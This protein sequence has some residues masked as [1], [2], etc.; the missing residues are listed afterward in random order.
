[1]TETHICP[2]C[3]APG[4]RVFFRSEDV[5][6]AD[7]VFWRTREAAIRCAK[8]DV[9]LAF[10]RRCECI[11]NL[12]LGSGSVAY[13]LDYENSLHFS[14]AFQE[15]AKA[16]AAELV[17]RHGLHNKTIVEI[18]CGKG[19]FLAMLCELGHNRGIG[20]DPS[21]ANGRG[22]AAAGAGIS[23]IREFYSASSAIPGCDFICCRH[24]LEHIPTPTQFLSDVRR[25][26]EKSGASVFFEVPNGRYTLQQNGIWDIIYPHATYFVSGSLR[27][28]FA[29]C[30]F[31]VESLRESFNG[32]YLSLEASTSGAAAQERVAPAF[33]NES[34]A[35][36]I[37]KFQQSYQKRVEDLTK[38]LD[39]LRKS[40]K[41]A[42][43]WGGGSKGVAFL[44]RF[45]AAP[46]DYVVDLNPHKQGNFV[47]G[48]GQQ[49]VAPE[50][51]REIQPGTIIIMN[52]NY[53]N[54]IQREVESL[55][56][57]PEFLL[58]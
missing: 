50:F 23:Y 16:L 22:N 34:V 32:Q 10:C 52:P 38:I 6:V 54:E 3:E 57:H 29:R 12:A 28:L 13:D 20:F 45:K 5:P 19:E 2:I 30:G 27:R 41:P 42:V 44:N 36:E 8:G 18:G 21:Y 33:Q 35:D 43:V 49:V 55:G 11:T 9:E 47:S 1:M 37:E 14:P 46:V 4:L 56:I 24:V 58:A 40:P 25:N 7:N 26:A 17:H 31:T 15:Y 39:E 51:L 53:R 48:T